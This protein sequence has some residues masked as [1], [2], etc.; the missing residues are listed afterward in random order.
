MTLIGSGGATSG[1]GKG[2]AGATRTPKTAKDNL[3]STQYA[4]LIDVL[5]EGEIQGLVD[6]LESIYLDETPIQNADNSYNFDGVT[7]VTRTGTQDQA[8]ITLAKRQEVG[9][10]KGVGVPVTQA[11]PVVRQIDN[12]DVDAVRVTIAVPQ[13]QR[14]KDNGDIDGSF[15]DVDIDVQYAGG[16]WQTVNEGNKRVED[17]TGDL[18]T[19]DFR[20]EL[21]GAFPVNI[22]V[23]RENPDSTDPKNTN[24]FS[25]Q[26]YTEITYAKLAYPN[27][28]C[29]GLRVDASQFSRIPSRQYRIRGKKIAIPSNA[30]VDASTGRLIY[31]GTWN[32]QFGAAVWCS[33][34]AWCLYDLLVANRYG[35]G[36]HI[37][38]ASLDKWSFYAC[39]QYCS[40]LVPDGFGGTEPRFSC[41]VNIQTQDEAFKLISDM[42]SVFRAMPFWAAGS[43]ALSQ[44]RPADPVYSFNQ[45]NVVDGIFTYSSS[46]LKNRPTVVSAAYLDLATRDVAYESVESQELIEKYG[47]VRRDVA[48]FACT[49][50]GQARRVAEWVLYS[51]WEENEI[52]SFKA[53][54]DAGVM[55]RPGSR[56][57]IA[58]PLK[59]GVRHGGRIVSGTTTFLVVDSAEGLPASM[60][61]CTL[62][63][64]MPDGVTQTRPITSRSGTTITVSS[65]FS[66]APNA[67]APW[68]LSEPTVQTSLWTV[69]GLK[70][71]NGIEYEITCISHNPSKYGYIEQDKPLEARDTTNLNEPP[72]APTAVSVDEVMYVERAKAK[73]KLVVSWPGVP[74]V[75]SYAIEWRLDSGNWNR[76]ECETNSDIIESRAGSYEIRVYSIGANLRQSAGFATTTFAAAGNT[77]P[78]NRPG[79]LTLT[80]VSTSAL[81]LRWTG[82]INAAGAAVVIDLDVTYGGL[83][84]VRRSS[85][86]GGATWEASTPIAV[87]PGDQT[88]VEVAAMTGTYLV[89]FRDEAGNWSTSAT[90]IASIYTAPATRST[91]LTLDEINDFPSPLIPW[92]GRKDGTSNSTPGVLQLATGKLSGD[93]HLAIGARGSGTWFS[94]GVVDLGRIQDLF[95]R[96][97]ITANV[98]NGCAVRVFVSTATERAVEPYELS[99][100]NVSGVYFQPGNA[101]AKQ[102]VW[103]DWVEVGADYIRGRCFRFKLTL[104]SLTAGV[105]PTVTGLVLDLQLDSRTESGN[106]SVASLFTV[107][108]ADSPV[109]APVWRIE[110]Q[111]Q[112]LT[113]PSAFSVTGISPSGISGQLYASTTEPT[114]YVYAKFT[115]TSTGANATPTAFTWSVTGL[116]ADITAASAMSAG[117]MSAAQVQKLAALTP[118]TAPTNVVQLDSSARLPA[119]DASQLVNVPAGSFTQTGS[120]A[121]ARA[122]SSKLQDVIHVRDFGAVGN[123]TTDDTT[124]IQNAINAAQSRTGGCRVLF[125]GGNYRITATLIVSTDRIL[126]EGSGGTRITRNSN[127]GYSIRF[128]EASRTTSNPLFNVGIRNIEFVSTGNMSN[129]AQLQMVA[130]RI[131]WIEGVTVTNGYAGIELLG[132]GSMNINDIYI[133]INKDPITNGQPTTF[134]DF[135]FYFGFGG[136]GACGEIFMTN[137]NMWVGYMTAIGQPLVA[138]ANYGIIGASIDGLWM[139]N[140]HVACSRLANFTFGNLNG[141]AVYNIYANGCMSD[142]CLGYGVDLVGTSTIVGF[143]WNG[144]ISGLGYAEGVGFRVIA[145]CFDIK[146][147]GLIDGHK[148][149]GIYISNP[150]ARDITLS[151]FTIRGCNSDNN[152]DGDGIRIGQGRRIMISNG[153]ING[154]DPNTGSI[155]TNTGIRLLSENGYSTSDVS[156]SN[157]VIVRNK[158][159]LDIVNTVVDV[160]LSSVTLRSNTSDYTTNGNPIPRLFISNCPGISPVLGGANWTPGTIGAGS[161]A[162]TTL[163]ATGA[164]LGDWVS[165]ASFGQ[166]MQGCILSAWV[167]S[168]D[169][170]IVIIQNP[171][172]SSKTFATG[173]VVVEVTRR[174]TT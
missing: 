114:R 109:L 115:N 127:F 98:P 38:S 63:I 78:P 147:S 4:S 54:I 5:C 13:L 37:S 59:A 165:M 156:I 70:E 6:G 41:N 116:G 9:S 27:T 51:E 133:Q 68:V 25:W 86:T 123:G 110:I 50:R 99:Q 43:V 8:P 73:T 3:A 28:A 122:V 161:Q 14:V 138:F 17:R 33:D 153:V 46:S 135:G 113:T 52:C 95:I 128:Y 124:A 167:E 170:V 31:S 57:E 85:A 88:Q 93:Y 83:A 92:P 82:A 16:S 39:S 60:T 157:V 24:E 120:G 155:V 119:V 101:V 111:P 48:A 134:A 148:L 12:P 172:A 158:M 11:A 30:T 112:F 144:R 105:T 61:G 64:V 74:G 62:S 163:T 26:S 149:H 145:P 42:C 143:Q 47:V 142:H 146:W 81:M 72:T 1:G 49:S 174:L 15:F 169:T 140:V 164:R 160:V 132:C 102:P 55:L 91:L 44:D 45:S 162:F 131:G 20:F 121:I 21:N 100:G 94:S 58:D 53:S 34:P 129:S 69:L 130:C 173:S 65:A 159:G 152:S 137:I 77:A 10:E 154:E 125:D 141:S 80:T 22:R 136:G 166:P 75:T 117:L 40:G 150:N 23:S 168:N 97:S 151:D 139:T 89:K 87:V 56:V 90:S 36:T 118:G 103:S 108:I 18:W 171:T 104:E 67:L 79:G 29:V 106:Q 35:F 96:R 7:V 2:G 71:S 32:G 66:V 126:L 107:N 84:E 19:K 76:L